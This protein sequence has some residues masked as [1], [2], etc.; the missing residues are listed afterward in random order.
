LL[1]EV[2]GTLLAVNGIPATP[3]ELSCG[4]KVVTPT[5][6]MPGRSTSDN[7]GVRRRVPIR[8]FGQLRARL[9]TR[10]QVSWLGGVRR[11]AVR[12]HDEGLLKIGGA[13]VHE[14]RSDNRVPLK[15]LRES[16]EEGAALERVDWRCG[17]LDGGIFFDGVHALVTRDRVAAETMARAWRYF[18][19]CARS[20]S[21]SIALR[22]SCAASA[23]SRSSAQ[24]VARS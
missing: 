10:A 7:R 20:V 17:R 24:P 8:G 6:A 11:L 18:A 23:R 22:A 12:R 19:Q 15:L 16:F 13:T 5:L 21:A 1:H 2:A 4:R 9:L 14:A 3:I